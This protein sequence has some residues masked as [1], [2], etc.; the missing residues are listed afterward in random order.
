MLK[1]VRGFS[2]QLGLLGGSVTPMR[3]NSFFFKLTF[4]KSCYNSFYMSLIV[5]RDWVNSV[6]SSLSILIM[7]IGLSGV[8]FGL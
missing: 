3:I 6:T 7:V 5:F 4:S 8:Q 1:E 2:Q